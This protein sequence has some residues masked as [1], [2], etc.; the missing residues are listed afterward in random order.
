MKLLNFNKVL[1]LSPHPDDV[2][3]S[4]A[5]TIIKYQNTHFD[6]LTM[7]GGGDFEGSDSDI[8]HNEVSNVWN[9]F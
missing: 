8:R 6:I 5:G 2:E 4:M 9:S 7:S 3:Y 1:C